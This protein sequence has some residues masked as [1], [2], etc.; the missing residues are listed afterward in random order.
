MATL[1]VR[2]LLN[3]PCRFGQLKDALPGISAHTLTDRLRRFEAYGIV[4]RTSYPET[5]P[6]VGHELIN[7]L[8]ADRDPIRYGN[9]RHL[10]RNNTPL[11]SRSVRRCRGRA[12]PV[13]GVGCVLARLRRPVDQR[14]HSVALEYKRVGVELSFR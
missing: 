9:S 5:P 6:R 3:G 4:T 1:I 11:S 2:E 12:A 8:A 14:L 10:S 7:P 13:S